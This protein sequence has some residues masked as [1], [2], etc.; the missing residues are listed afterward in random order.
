MKGD[1]DM[2]LRLWVKVVLVL[3]LVAFIS[4]LTWKALENTEKEVQECV[5]QGYT[6]NYCTS[7]MK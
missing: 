2:K 7:K 1:K 4:V 3:L 6:R 5:E